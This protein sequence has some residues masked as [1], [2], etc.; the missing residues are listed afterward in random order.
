MI[1]VILE[2]KQSKSK[3]NYEDACDQLSKLGIRLGKE[4]SGERDLFSPDINNISIH[5][6][7]SS[8]G[9]SILELEFSDDD[10]AT[11]KL[12]Q[13]V[14]KSVKE[15]DGDVELEYSESELPKLVKDIKTL[16]K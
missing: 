2:G 16:I 14:D 6:V 9:N 3:S 1:K 13:K 8:K 5:G 10:E 12:V 4:R 11:L 7:I 15:L